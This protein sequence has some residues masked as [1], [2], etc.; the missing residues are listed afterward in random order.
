MQCRV[1]GD[2]LAGLRDG[3][4]GA[5]RRIAPEEQTVLTAQLEGFDA[6]NTLA[7]HHGDLSARRDVETRFDDTVIAEADTQPG[8]GAE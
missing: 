8:I 7:L 1:E 2:A 4:D 6:S 5:G 3:L